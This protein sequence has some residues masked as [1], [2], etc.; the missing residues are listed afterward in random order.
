VFG[1]GWRGIFLVVLLVAVFGGLLLCLLL[2]TFFALLRGVWC[3]LGSVNLLVLLCGINSGS[4]CVWPPLWGG[5]FFAL[6]LLL[7]AFVFSCPLSFPHY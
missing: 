7:A 5:F 1:N 4:F 6:L 2:L 3:G